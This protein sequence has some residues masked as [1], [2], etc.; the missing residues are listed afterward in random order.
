MSGGRGDS[1]SLGEGVFGDVLL[2]GSSELS[3]ASKRSHKSKKSKSKTLKS[4]HS[5]SSPSKSGRS[6]DRQVSNAGS[7]AAAGDG[8]EGRNSLEGE[9]GHTHRVGGKGGLSDAHKPIVG[10]EKRSSGR[11]CPVVRWSRFWETP[12]YEPPKA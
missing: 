10:S 7:G 6:N 9:L 4:S 3:I 2:S 11:V 8:A 12:L 1:L 5:H